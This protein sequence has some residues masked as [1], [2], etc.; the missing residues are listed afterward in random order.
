[1]IKVLKA[2]GAE[3]QQLSDWLEKPIGSPKLGGWLP[4][5]EDGSIKFNRLFQMTDGE[6]IINISKIDKTKIKNTV[7]WKNRKE[8][9]KAKIFN[10]ED[11]KHLIPD[12]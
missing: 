4:L 7:G 10:Y 3:L 1:M 6:Y 12:D 8:Q 9:I 2:T 5:N 11:I